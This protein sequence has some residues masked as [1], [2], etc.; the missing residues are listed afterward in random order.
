M[1]S[2]PSILDC[3]ELTSFIFSISPGLQSP[4]STACTHLPDL[5][6][7]DLAPRFH[8]PSLAISCSLSASWAWVLCERADRHS[9]AGEGHG[10][11]DPEEILYHSAGIMKS[12]APNDRRPNANSIRETGISQNG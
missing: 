12:P 4:K 2:C 3:P 6:H 8:P 9:S 5:G 10:A 11:L 7:D 1:K